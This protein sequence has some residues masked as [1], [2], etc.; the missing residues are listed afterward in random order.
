MAK[1]VNDDQIVSPPLPFPRVPHPFPR[2]DYPDGIEQ[3]AILYKNAQKNLT[4]PGPARTDRVVM[5]KPYSVSPFRLFI[6][7]TIRG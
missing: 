3:K 1:T 4:G 2:I 5:G 6:V 7:I